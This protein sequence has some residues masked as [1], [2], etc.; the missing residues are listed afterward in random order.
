MR[1]FLGIIAATAMIFAFALPVAAADKVTICHKT[2]AINN[3]YVAIKVAANSGYDPHLSDNPGNNPLAGH[4]Q[5]FLL[6]NTDLETCDQVP[7][8]EVTPLAPSVSD[9]TCEAAGTLTLTAVEGVT[10]TIEPE[11]TEGDSGDFTV[12]ATADEGLAIAEDAQTVFEVTVPAALDCPEGAEGAAPSI[13]APTCAA[14]GAL[15]L[16]PATG[17]TYSVEPAYALGDSGEFTVT[18]TADEGY[19]LSGPAS[20]TVNVPAKKV[21][22]DGTLGGNPPAGPVPNTAMAAPGSDQAPALVGLIAIA[23]LAFVARRNIT[24][25]TTRR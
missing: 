14:P 24:A 25:M 21:C 19:K 11:Y 23:G 20:F 13:S 16:N 17:V 18:A 6:E 9:A 15:T 7:D 22:N 3:P 10:Y 12:T 8:E 1:R 4:E 5:D 2:S